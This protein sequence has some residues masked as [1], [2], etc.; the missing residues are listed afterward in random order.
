MIPKKGST[1]EEW[2]ERSCAEMRTRMA[3]KAALL[4]VEPSAPKKLLKPIKSPKR[5]QALL[6][7]ATKR[8]AEADAR[9]ANEIVVVLPGPE[10]PAV[11]DPLKLPP[12]KALGRPKG[13]KDLPMEHMPLC[14][15]CNS[16]QVKRAGFANGRQ[17]YK[18]HDCTRRFM[19]Q[20]FRLVGP[21]TESVTLMCF[22]CGSTDVK[23]LGISPVSGRTGLCRPCKHRFIQGGRNELAK[24]HLL[25]EKRV[26]D[27]KLPKDVAAEALQLAFKDVIEGK[28]YCWTVEIRHKDAWKAVR[29]EFGQ[30]GS[31]HPEFRLQN[32]QR[33]IED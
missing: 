28:G 21:K 18:C 10:L 7:S 31:D 16:D 2:L 32:G 33:I 25:L 15:R 17:Q 4:H 12:R 26:A 9:Q 6:D 13:M 20:G 27:L 3:T 23:S 19:G 14:P 24:Y 1:R 29:G 5:L 22:R 11:I 8:T 30:R